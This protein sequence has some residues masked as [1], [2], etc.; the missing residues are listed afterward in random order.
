MM[1]RKIVFGGSK[2]QSVGLFFPVCALWTKVRQMKSSIREWLQ[3]SFP[4]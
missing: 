4:L 2:V 3:R 1:V